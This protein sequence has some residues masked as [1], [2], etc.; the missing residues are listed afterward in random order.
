MG[1]ENH[2]VHK[3]SDGWSPVYVSENLAVI[4]IGFLLPS[5]DDAVIW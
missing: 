2:E 5:K 3:S 1:L 4:S